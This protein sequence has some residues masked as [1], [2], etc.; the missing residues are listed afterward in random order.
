MNEIDELLDAAIRAFTE[1]KEKLAAARLR[2]EESVDLTAAQSSDP[3]ALLHSAIS[4]VLVDSLEPAL[5]DLGNL[6]SLGV[7]PITIRPAVTEDFNAIYAL[8]VES[9]ALARSDRL[10]TA[11]ETIEHAIREPNGVFLVAEDSGTVAGFIYAIQETSTTAMIRYLAV[12]PK[13]RRRGIATRLLGTC[14]TT[15]AREWDIKEVSAFVRPDTPVSGILGMNG[16]RR[17]ATFVWMSR[18]ITTLV[19]TDASGESEPE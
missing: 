14:L 12:I 13:L 1:G 16:F 19:E 6:D 5:R 15:L 3:A 7:F 18:D 8:I 2:L 11:P 9:P 17:G 4:C 10:I